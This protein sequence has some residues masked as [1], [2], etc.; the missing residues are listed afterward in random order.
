MSPETYRMRLRKLYSD[1]LELYDAAADNRVLK[2]SLLHLQRARAA[3][4]SKTL[5]F[6]QDK[7]FQGQGSRRY[8]EHVAVI[9]RRRRHPANIT[10]LLAELKR[11]RPELWDIQY[12]QFHPCLRSELRHWNRR[13]AEFPDKNGRKQYGLP[14]WKGALPYVPG[15]K[16]GA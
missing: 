10:E 4:D 8:F 6:K 1:M 13:I 5:T 14:H 11:L 3:A 2:R 16:C 12:R 7:Q 9:L 15:V